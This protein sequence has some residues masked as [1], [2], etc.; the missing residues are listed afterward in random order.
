MRLKELYFVTLFSCSLMGCVAT[1]PLISNKSN[2]DALE[3]ISTCLT[4][5]EMLN[6]TQ[7]PHLY[8]KEFRSCDSSSTNELV[9]RYIKSLILIGDF[10]ELHN[11]DLL[12]GKLSIKQ[13]NDWKQKL[14]A[15]YE[16]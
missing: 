12:K 8:V 9:L 5:L 3:S 13:E 16:N 7:Q 2:V 10:A 1:E 4:R 11:P 14:K 6:E 15:Y